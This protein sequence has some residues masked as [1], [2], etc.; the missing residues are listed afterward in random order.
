M[1]GVIFESAAGYTEA[2]TVATLLSQAKGQ[3]IYGAAS[4]VPLLRIYSQSSSL[5]PHK[6]LMLQ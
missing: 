3:R 4:P 2:W 1:P 6:L 5:R